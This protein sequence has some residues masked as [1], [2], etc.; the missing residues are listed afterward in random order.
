MHQLQ[1][2]I[3]INTY[4]RAAYLKRLLP[5]LTHLRDVD[6][7]VVVVNGPSTDDT[8]ALLA[9]YAD[10]IKVVDCPSRNLSHSRNLGIAAA[11]GE[12]V[13]FIDDDALP[14]DAD[15]LA[16]YVAAFRDGDARLG[17][18]GGPVWHRDTDRYEFNGGVTS[19]YGEQV[20]DQA[21]IAALAVGT[22]ARRRSRPRRTGRSRSRRCSGRA[23]GRSGAC[24]RSA[25]ASA[26]GAP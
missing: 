16:R 6:F 10:R 22:A 9:S 3:I 4:N 12:V 23:G 2:S 21:R 19:D 1:A 14:G 25:R 24:R 15:W 18:L 17:A 26:A 13:V 5:G 7:E 11:A 8:A 20:F